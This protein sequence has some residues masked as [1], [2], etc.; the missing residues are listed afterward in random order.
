MIAL[1]G[2]TT[3]AND[4]PEEIRSAVLEMFDE[5]VRKNSVQLSNIVS[6]LFTATKDVRSAYPGKFLRE[7][8]AVTGAAILHFQEMDVV[9]SLSQCIRVLIYCEGISNPEHAYLRGAKGLRP[10][11]SGL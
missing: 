2:A 7:D 4:T 9:E 10:D 3:V 11:I 1:R 8:R 5:L 6:I